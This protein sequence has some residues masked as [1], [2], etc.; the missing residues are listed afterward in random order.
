[1]WGEE[2]RKV[3]D[4]WLESYFKERPQLREP[5]KNFFGEYD[6]QPNIRAAFEAMAKE[7][8]SLSEKLAFAECAQQNT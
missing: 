3:L 4:V 7:N 2:V 5:T 6:M 1:M 8:E